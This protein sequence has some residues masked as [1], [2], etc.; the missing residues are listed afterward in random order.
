MLII[1]T[2]FRSAT[3]N[4]FKDVTNVAELNDVYSRIMEDNVENEYAEKVTTEAYVARARELAEDT[5]TPQEKAE[6]YEAVNNM[7]EE[8]ENQNR[9]QKVGTNYYEQ[10]FETSKNKAQIDANMSEVDNSA[11]IPK[12]EENA[13]ESYAREVKNNLRKAPAMALDTKSPVTVTGIAESNNADTKLKLS[14]GSQ[15]S[16]KDV[17]FNDSQTAEVYKRASNYNT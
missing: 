14:N 9:I 8:R 13:N 12:N 7:L 1:L 16:I 5:K 4:T 15:I 3:E 17:Q 10:I 6:L 2:S 11:L